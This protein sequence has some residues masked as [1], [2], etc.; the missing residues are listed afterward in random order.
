[1]ATTGG[2]PPEQ[3]DQQHELGQGDDKVEGGGQVAPDRIP[4]QLP[5]RE[6]EIAAAHEVDIVDGH[7]QQIG[8]EDGLHPLGPVPPQR[9]RR[10]PVL[11]RVSFTPLRKK[12]PE[13]ETKLRR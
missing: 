1:M 13:T 3:G 10:E 11:F 9:G 2:Q 5:Q 4:R 12:K 8:Q 6:G 7:C